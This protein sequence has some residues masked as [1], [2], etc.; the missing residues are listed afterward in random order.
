LKSFTLFRICAILP[1][2]T[3]AGVAL[4]A[5]PKSDPARAAS[6]AVAAKKKNQ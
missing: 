4:A 5:A 6:P 3:A 1:A 2:G